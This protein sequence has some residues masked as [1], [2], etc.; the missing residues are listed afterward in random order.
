MTEARIARMWTGYV[1]SGKAARYKSLMLEVA[2]P[3]YRSVEGNAGAW[4]LSHELPSGL[5]EFRMLTLW[6]SIEAIKTFAGEDYQ[7]AL[8]Y[9]FD[10]EFLVEKAELV[11]HFEVD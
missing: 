4:C 11:E 8:Y 9:D 2:L 10:D 3:H 5:T 1:P 7:T 6:D